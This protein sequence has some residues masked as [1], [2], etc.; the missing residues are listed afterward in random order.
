MTNKKSKIIEGE[1]KIITARERGQKFENNKKVIWYDKKM[2]KISHKILIGW[3]LFVLLFQVAFVID[4]RKCYANFAETEIWQK[5][6]Y[7]IAVGIEEKIQ[8]LWEDKRKI[9]IK[10]L[11]KLLQKFDKKT[12]TYQLINDI[13]NRVA[14]VKKIS[15][16]T[17]NQK[18]KVSTISV[19]EWYKKQWCND[20][21]LPT[22]TWFVAGKVFFWWWISPLV[23]EDIYILW[24]IVN[25]GDLDGDWIDEVQLT[26]NWCRSN[27]SFFSL[28]SYKK[29]KWQKLGSFNVYRWQIEKDTSRYNN[30]YEKR[31]KIIKKWLIEISQDWRNDDQSEIVK[32]VNKYKLENW[33]LKL[34]NGK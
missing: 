31:I 22:T 3:L 21:Y 16:D 25:V 29:G 9:Y 5:I 11:E 32:K 4:N 12:N 7:D 2:L 10:Q 8:Y 23:Y 24:T 18:W 6:A 30:P 34:Y 14:N 17:I 19:V 26:D 27:R 1:N 20:G 15:I 28:Y 33:E 13:K